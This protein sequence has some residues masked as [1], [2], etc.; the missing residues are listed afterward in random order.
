MLRNQT[1]WDSACS[2]M[3]PNDNCNGAPA[4]MSAGA[5]LLWAIVP[6]IAITTFLVGH[7]W[8]YR[9]DQFGWTSGSTQLFEHKILGWAGPAFLLNE[10]LVWGFTG[11]VI[12]AML[13]VAGWARPWD[14]TDVRALDEAMTLVGEGRGRR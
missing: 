13:D 6:Y 12:S 2:A 4:A 10:M 11:Q 3:C 14:T 1:G 7:W 9:F 5:I 8:R